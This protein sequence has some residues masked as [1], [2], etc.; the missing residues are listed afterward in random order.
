VY[1]VLGRPR[2][3]KICLYNKHF[4]VCHIRDICDFPPSAPIALVNDPSNLVGLCRNH[5]WEL[6]HELLSTEDRIKLNEA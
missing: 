6:D 3:C 5:H 4:D 2:R 1:R